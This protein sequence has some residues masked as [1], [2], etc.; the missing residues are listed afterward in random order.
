M[1][2]EIQ[3]PPRAYPRV[4][5]AGLRTAHNLLPSSLLPPPSSLGSWALWVWVVVLV[6]VCG[7]SAWQPQV[8][9]LYPTWQAA[10]QAWLHCEDLYPNDLSPGQELYR[11]GP[12]A[13]LVFVPFSL[14]PERL[15]NVLWRLLGAGLFLG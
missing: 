14:L 15:G 2:E 3:A 9:N 13:T 4:Q 5:E 10:G 1:K 8:R 11:Y 6:A 12:S 7:R